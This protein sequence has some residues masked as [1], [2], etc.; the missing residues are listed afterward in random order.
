MSEKK[1]L[2]K[3]ALEKF[4]SLDATKLQ[5]FV[6][7]QMPHVFL[8]FHSKLSDADFENVVS[9]VVNQAVNDLWQ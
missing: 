9:Y 8:P 2:R 4:Q 6:Q 5:T 3:E 7:N 1:T